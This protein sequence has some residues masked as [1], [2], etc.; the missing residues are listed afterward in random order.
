[1]PRKKYYKRKQYQNDDDFNRFIGAIV[2]ILF[3]LGIVIKRKIEEEF[4][5]Y[6]FEN[7]VYFYLFLWIIVF[8]ILLIIVYYYFKIRKTNFLEKQR[9]EKIPEIVLNIKKEVEN[10][11]P[12]RNYSKEEPYQLELSWYLKNF[13]PNLD[14]E[15]SK[16]YTRPDIIVDN[17]AIEIKWPTN[18]SDL[19]TIPD[20]IIR[21]TKEWDYLIIV[22]FNLK[23]SENQETSDKIFDEWMSDIEENFSSKMDRILIIKK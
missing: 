16:N 1:M 2:V 19:K 18:F 15:I 7:I 21:Y 22:L 14:I 11:T 23:L 20:K 3:F 6:F 17:I 10:F 5:P 12:L 4:I 8:L 13:F 9:L